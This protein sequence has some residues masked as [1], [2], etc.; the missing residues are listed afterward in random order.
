VGHWGCAQAVRVR[1]RNA[2]EQRHIH[3][4]VGKRGLDHVRGHGRDKDV[5]EKCL[6]ASD[7]QG[8]PAPVVSQAPAA[9]WLSKAVAGE[10]GRCRGVVLVRCA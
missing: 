7:E 6:E 2:I 9:K 4:Y 5:E 3:A 8:R 10:I 1:P